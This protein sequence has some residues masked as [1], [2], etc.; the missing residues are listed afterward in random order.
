MAWHPYIGYQIATCHG[1]T[2]VD[3][4]PCTDLLTY[5]QNV[6]SYLYLAPVNRFMKGIGE[7]IV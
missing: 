3:T 1:S 5:A 6:G 7:L 2:N 4:S